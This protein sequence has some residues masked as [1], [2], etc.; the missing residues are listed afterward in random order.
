MHSTS[1]AAW[2]RTDV[3][4]MQDPRRLEDLTGLTELHRSAAA[5][6]ADFDDD[7]PSDDEG[8]LV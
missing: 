1:V 6:A 5:L 3:W 2:L 7:Q 4:Q 8:A